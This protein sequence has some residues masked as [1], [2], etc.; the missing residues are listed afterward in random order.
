MLSDL[1]G[2]V[3]YYVAMVKPGVILF[4]IAGVT[5]VLAREALRL[6]D[7]KIGYPCRFVAREGA[8]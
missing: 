2:P 8:V 4:E 7:T 1:K 3:E 5:A 6:A